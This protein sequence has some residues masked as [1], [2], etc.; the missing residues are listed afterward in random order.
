[1]LTAHS[2]LVSRIRMSRALRPLLLYS[3]MLWSGTLPLVNNNNNHK[4]YMG[5]TLV[6]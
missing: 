2:H 3:S 1:M 5:T 4:F 6:Q